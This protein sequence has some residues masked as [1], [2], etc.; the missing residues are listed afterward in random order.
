MLCH[1]MEDK[2]HIKKK[3]ILTFMLC[4]I[5]EDEKYIEKEVVLALFFGQYTIP[6]K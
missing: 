2:K 3:V 6:I 4:H 1:I 5:T